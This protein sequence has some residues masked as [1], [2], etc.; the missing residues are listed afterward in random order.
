MLVLMLLVATVHGWIGTQP[1]LAASLGYTY[2]TFGQGSTITVLGSTDQ[3][4]TFGAPSEIQ[5]AGKMALGMRRG[6][7]IAASR[8]AVI[9]TAVVGARGG[10][11][12]GDVV[13]YRSVDRGRSWAPATVI[14][15]VPGSAREGLHGM[16]A[17]PG[18]LMV[19]TWLDLRQKG[20]RLYAAVSRDHGATWSP[21]V[22]VYESSSGSVCECCHP[23]VDVSDD[24]GI[25]VMFRNS[26]EGNRDMYVTRSRDGRTFEPAVKLGIGTWPLQGC[27][28]DGGAV[29]LS[30]N[31]MLATWRR[32][33]GVFL[34]MGTG[35]EQRLGTGRDSVVGVAGASPDVAWSG[36]EGVVLWRPEGT[37]TPLGPG[38]FPSLLSFEQ[39]TLVAW[40]D[41]GRVHVGT[42]PR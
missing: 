11:A 9:V 24:G 30:A 3:G 25:A 31:G 21:D 14:N 20:T 8:D 41:Q 42:V 33:D 12:D 32:E 18:G 27:P 29:L 2:L 38:R 6:P 37:P 40:E 15:D 4:V 19:V 5:V 13:L 1:Q 22:L 36:A 10:G 35:A 17:N 26:L 23:S 39:H 28:M 34:T 16:A 7:R